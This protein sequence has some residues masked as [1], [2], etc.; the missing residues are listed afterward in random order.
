VQTIYVL[1]KYSRIGIRLYRYRAAS[2]SAAGIRNLKWPEDEALP[3]TLSRACSSW[4]N[5]ASARRLD[6]SSIRAGTHTHQTAEGRGE[7]TL[8][9]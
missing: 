2:E 1:E 8:L 3:A 7:M 4:R 5:L 6:Q 9:R